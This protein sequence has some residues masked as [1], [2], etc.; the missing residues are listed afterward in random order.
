MTV[1][2][3]RLNRSLFFGA[4]AALS[5]GVGACGTP[6]TEVEEPVGSVDGTDETAMADGDAAQEASFDVTLNGA[7]ASFPAP[8][9]QTWFSELQSQYP[10]LRINYQSVGSGAGIEQYLSGTVDFGATDAP[11]TDEE[12][13]SFID[14]Y[15][16]DPIQV[17]M[18][19]GL[20]VFAYNLP[21]VEG[22][23]QLTTDAYCGIVSG[24]ITQWDAEP[25]ASANPD[26]TLP[27]DPINFV[28]RSDG[29]GTTFLFTNHISEVCPNW[30]AGAA[31]TVDWPVGVGAKGN[32]GIAAQVQQTEGAVGYVEYTYASENDIPMATLENSAGNFI[33][34]S[35]DAAA[36]AFEDVEVPEDFALL[37]PNPA[38]DQAYPIAGL[39][40][41]LIYPSYD[42]PQTGEAIATM[43]NWAQE[44]GDEYAAQL[45]Y[46]PLPEE[47]SNRVMDTV[48]QQIASR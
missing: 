35:P 1:R 40:W 26:L 4:I 10:G 30:T 12:R 23:L 8:L 38:A 19:G 37:V 14:Q 28:H 25:I 6:E 33:E 22:D 48:Q 21:G 42:D 45:G 16:S 43:V 2:Q 36:T 11:L 47:V 15:G 29:S 27:S 39:T 3:L 5:F 18:T 13:Q 7:G 46:I 32:E 20:V 34:P 17:P 24:E 41:L 44:E 31:K 9:Y